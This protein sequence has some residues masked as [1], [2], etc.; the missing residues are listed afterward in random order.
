MIHAGGQ[1]QKYKLTAA[2]NTMGVR[3]FG[4]ASTSH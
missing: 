1:G 2:D 3:I 4:V